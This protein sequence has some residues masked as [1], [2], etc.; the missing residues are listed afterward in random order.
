MCIGGNRFGG[1]S[2][3]G[4]GGKIALKQPHQEGRKGE[5]GRTDKGLFVSGDF[6]LTLF[7]CFLLL[8]DPIC[9]STQTDFVKVLPEGGH[10]G[11]SRAFCLALELVSLLGIWLPTPI[12]RQTHL[13]QSWAI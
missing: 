10:S 4:V 11:G 13:L 2:S 6:K 5:V 8:D 1:D 9:Y 12:S 3:S 7:H